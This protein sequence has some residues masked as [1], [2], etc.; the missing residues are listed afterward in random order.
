MRK[1][2]L[3]AAVALAASIISSEAQ[4]YSQNIVGYVNQSA[5]GGGYS[6]VTVPLSASPT[7]APEQVFSGIQ[8]GDTILIWTNQ[9]YSFYTFVS[10]GQW[11]YPDQVTIGAGPNLPPGSTL[12]LNPGVTETNTYTGSVIL[13]NT[14]SPI[15]LPGGLYTL[16]GSLPPIGVTTLEDTNLNLPL[17]SGDAVLLWDSVHNQYLTYTFI[18]P[19]QWLEPDQVTVGASPAMPVAQ[20]FF[21]NPGL[22]EHWSQNLNVQ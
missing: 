19:G 16:I 5:V 1:T 6:L 15:T 12:F 2:L 22:T 9:S 7:N 14:N 10:P 3:I 4:V 11:L 8:S 13:S 21:Y 20:G 17:Q 18:S